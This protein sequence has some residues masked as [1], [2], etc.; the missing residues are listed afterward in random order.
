MMANQATIGGDQ[1]ADREE[2]QHDVVRDCNKPLDE[3]EAT[4]LRRGA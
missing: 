2:K 4:A 3:R 1:R